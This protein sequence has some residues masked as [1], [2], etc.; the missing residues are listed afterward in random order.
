MLPADPDALVLGAEVALQ[1]GRYLDAS[2]AYVR[3]ALASEDETVAEQAA[4]LAYEHEQW[5]QVL[6]AADRWLALNPTN[7]E[8]QRFAA[9]AALHLY[10][11]DTAEEH[12]GILLNTAFISP[13]AGFL[14]LLPQLVEEASPS[15]ATAVLQRLVPRFDD[16]TEA[17]YALAQAAIRS[18][19]YALARVHA[20][21]ARELGAYW[22]P[23]GLLLARV[24]MLQGET[25][26]ALATARTVIAQEDLDVY[27]LEYALMLLQAGEETEGRRQLLA[28]SD[29][30]TAGA[31]VERALADI[32]FQ[33]G[34]RSAAARRFGHLVSTGR[35]VYESLF[36]L[37]ALAEQQDNPEDALQFY[38]RV[39]GGDMAMASQAR[40]ARLKA[41]REG[42]EAG[43][44]HLREFAA[45]RPQYRIDTLVAQASLRGSNA[46]SAG[47]LALLD[48]ALQDYPDSIE[49]RFAR[50][51]QLEKTDK[52][53]ES[54]AALRKIVAD[55]PGDPTAENALGYTL[56]DRTRAYQEGFGL[57][58]R[59]L[60]QAPDNGAVLD[61]MGWALHR[62]GRHVEALKYLEQARGRIDDP[63][64]DLHLGAVLLALDRKAEAREVW[65]QASER[66]PDNAELKR[67]L[68][69]LE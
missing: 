53:A 46:D 11:I 26:A 66:Y 9:F 38:E 36:Y 28:L 22:A 63:E 34:N 42:L 24:Q 16:M 7:E 43:L 69:K 48:T 64:L 21:R 8:A 31:M 47:A 25:D 13:Q 12:L 68:Q 58:E 55:R 45:T 57:I 65:R 59:A 37:G 39:T 6:A 49:L 10:R 35:F 51:F 17:H 4:R 5:T 20:R 14:A 3:A 50:V 2:R 30:E 1:R 67:Q 62:L 54:V 52:V 29:S 23:A 19:N 33:L 15:A 32:D 61:S 18:D 56:V 40:A 27:R 44:V 60:A 41:Q